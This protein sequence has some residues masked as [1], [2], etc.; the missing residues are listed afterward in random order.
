[1]IA[2]A[3]GLGHVALSED[4]MLKYARGYIKWYYRV[5]HPLM[6]EHAP[7]VEYT[8]LVPPYKEVIVE[9]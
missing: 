3:S 2:C 1:M 8:A 9:Q 6:S 5:F 7:V 4:K